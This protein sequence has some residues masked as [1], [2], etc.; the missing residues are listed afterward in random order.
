MKLNYLI[1]LATLLIGVSCKKDVVDAT[2][3][4]KWQLVEQLVDPGNG[5]GTF[6]PVVSSKTLELFSDGTFISNENMCDTGSS[7]L[8]ATTG[9]YSLDNYTLTP[10]NCA[11]TSFKIQFSLES[12]Y[13]IISN[14]CIEPCRDKY[15]KIDND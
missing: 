2:L 7:N 15:K 10:E 3:V 5:S 6:H 1:V 9:T 11:F 12:E 14:P 8:H 4:G 13:L